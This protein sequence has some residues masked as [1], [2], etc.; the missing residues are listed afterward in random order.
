MIIMEDKSSLRGIF[1]RSLLTSLDYVQT[2]AYDCDSLFLCCHHIS[3]S[4]E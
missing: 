1:G 2:L 4:R 3:E